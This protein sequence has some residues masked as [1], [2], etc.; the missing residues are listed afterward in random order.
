ML[1]NPTN[2]KFQKTKTKIEQKLQS[3]S[4]KEWWLIFMFVHLFTLTHFSSSGQKG[5]GLS[6]LQLNFLCHN[7]FFSI[8]KKSRGLLTRLNWTCGRS[9]CL[10]HF[11]H[12]FYFFDCILLCSVLGVWPTNRRGRQGQIKTMRSPVFIRSF[13]QVVNL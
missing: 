11:H 2:V 12:I 8:M 10:L 13:P 7:H 3:F 5:H 6:A 1:C 4:R 9:N